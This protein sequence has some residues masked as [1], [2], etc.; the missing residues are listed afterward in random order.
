MYRILILLVV[1]GLLAAACTTQSGDATG[2]TTGTAV[3]TPAA[4]S[5]AT[6]DA[7]GTGATAS[8]ECSESFGPIAEE[9]VTSI[10]DLG[11]LPELVEPTI[12][13]CASVDEWIA[14]AQQLFDDDINPSTV[15]LLLGIQCNSPSL[16]NTDLCQ[17]VAS[18]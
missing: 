3:S 18:S 6:D 8:T 9:N 13:N 2:E 16:A 12:E 17:D 4:T 14:G 7:A 10:A 5:S 1:I 11:D 15:R